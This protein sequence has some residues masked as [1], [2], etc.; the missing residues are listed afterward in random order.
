MS[1][2]DDLLA[3]TDAPVFSVMGDLVTYTPPAGVAAA[4]TLVAT[5]PLAIGVEPAFNVFWGHLAD[6]AVTPVVGGVV[7]SGGVDY[8]IF[9]VRPETDGPGIYLIAQRA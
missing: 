8:K 6:F 5:D 7:A 9:Q 4:V 2:F 1:F 3:V